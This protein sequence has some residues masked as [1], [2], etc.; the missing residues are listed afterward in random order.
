MRRGCFFLSSQAFILSVTALFSPLIPDCGRSLRRLRPESTSTCTV[1]PPLSYHRACMDTVSLCGADAADVF[2]WLL[3]RDNYNVPSG[4]VPLSV[5]TRKKTRCM[6]E[7]E[8]K[9]IYLFL[10][11]T[12]PL[13]NCKVPLKGKVASKGNPFNHPQKLFGSFRVTRVCKTKK[14]GRFREKR[15]LQIVRMKLWLLIDF[16]TDDTLPASVYLN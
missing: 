9:F 10:F 7:R 3:G 11:L 1:K 2:T 16:R 5:F 15:K 6:F 8:I 4:V 12:N 13:C 14:I